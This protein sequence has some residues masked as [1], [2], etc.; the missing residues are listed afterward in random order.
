VLLAQ[1]DVLNPAPLPIE[2][3]EPAVGIA[4]GIRLAVFLPEQFQGQ[5]PVA[6]EFLVNGGEVGWRVDTAAGRLG[7]VAKKK[8]VEFPVAEVLGQRP[9]ELGGLRQFQVLV[10][11]ALN[12]GATAGDL[13]LRQSHR[14]QP[15]NLSNFT[16]GQSLFWQI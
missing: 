15:Q 1:G 12:D 4:A 10:N 6:L 8:L 9:A 7:P 13:V 11:G 5:I 2:I 14:R 3:A 16:H